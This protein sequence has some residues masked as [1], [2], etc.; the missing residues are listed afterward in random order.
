MLKIDIS[1]SSM[2]A[3][4]EAFKGIES[5]LPRNLAVAINRTAKTVRVQAAEDLGKVM[6]LKVN[7]ALRSDGDARFTPA[8]TLKKAI[9]QKSNADAKNLFAKIGLW[10]GHPFPLKYF[11]ARPVVRRK[12]LIGVRYKTDKAWKE[13]QTEHD[14]F[15]IKRWGNNIYKR[16]GEGRGPL[17]KLVGPKPGD[18]F[19]SHG[20]TEKAMEVARVALVTNVE[21]RINDVLKAQRGIIKLKKGMT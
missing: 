14:A 4:R 12:R 19:E 5:K 17:T 15:V 1:Q 6:N 16:K 11:D 10:Q 7:A 20:I 9:K 3:L 8:R 2:K 13:K 18:Y 21:R